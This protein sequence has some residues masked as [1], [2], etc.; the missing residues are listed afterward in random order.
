[1]WETNI[2]VRS[3]AFRLDGDLKQAGHE[4]LEELLSWRTIRDQ[5]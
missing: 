4:V 2:S 1:M 5:Q 3:L